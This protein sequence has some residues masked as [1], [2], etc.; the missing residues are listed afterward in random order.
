L[1]NEF[2]LEVI[3]KECYSTEIT[4]SKSWFENIQVGHSKIKMK[5]D[6][7]AETNTIPWKTL[8]KIDGIP[9]LQPST[10]KLKGLGGSL[11]HHLGSADVRMAVGNTSIVCEIFVTRD[12][13]TPILGLEAARKLSLVEKGKNAVSVHEVVQKTSVTMQMIKDT[14]NDIFTGIGKFPGEQSIL[15]TSNAEAVVQSPRRVP[16]HLHEPLKKEL[17]RMTETGVIEPVDYPT[18]WVHNIVITEKKNGQLRIC[19]DPQELNKYIKRE[20]F[21]TP[22]LQEI[23][24]SITSPTI[25]TVIDMASAFWQIQLNEESSQLC[26]FHTPFGRYKF[27]RL[28]FGIASASEILQKKNYQMFGDIPHVHII[29]DDIMI[30]GTEGEHDTALIALLERAKKHNIKFSPTKLQFKQQEVLY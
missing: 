9:K 20:H 6:T 21:Q 18:E 4:E 30:E 27:N 23:S 24:A 7:G 10:V 29:A 19:L 8:K 2:F 3:E 22:T 1:F 28:P 14:Y 16:H 15:L 11:I 12:K 17:A 25:F 5:I 13:S 26:T